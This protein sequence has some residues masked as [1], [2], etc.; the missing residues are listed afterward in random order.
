MRNN[1]GLYKRSGGIYLIK[2]FQKHYH[3]SNGTK[4]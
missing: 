2:D 4:I 1:L 3:G